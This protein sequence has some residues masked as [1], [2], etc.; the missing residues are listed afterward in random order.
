MNTVELIRSFISSLVQIK[1]PLHPPFIKGERGGFRQHRLSA[2]IQ[3]PEMRNYRNNIALAVAALVALLFLACLPAWAADE[4]R[5][6]TEPRTWGFPRDH[7]AHPEFRTEWWYFTGNLRDGAGNRYGYQ[8]TFFRQ[9]VRL[10]PANPKNPWSL[11]DLYPAHFAV[12]DV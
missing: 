8:L 7:G 11:R 4:W 5:Q 1:S 6:A 9:G 12:T 10:K 3:P 2:L